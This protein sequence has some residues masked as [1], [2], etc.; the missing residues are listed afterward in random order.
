MAKYRQ[1][2]TEFWSDAFVL[3]LTPEEKYFYLYLISNSHTTQ[4]GIYELPKRIIETHTGYNRETVDK[5]LKRFEEYNKISY[6]DK[7]KEIMIINWAK[8][9]IPSNPNAIKCVNK[10]IKSVKNKEFIIIL[11]KQYSDLKLDMHKLFFGVED[12]NIG[13][14]KQDS[15]KEDIRDYEG[16]CKD[17]GSN[18]VISNKE[19]ITN[20]KEEVIE[21]RNDGADTNVGDVLL[22]FK[23]NVYNPT[24][25]EHKKILE[26]GEKINCD[27]IISA[28]EEAISYN[29]K[30]IKYIE[31]IINTWIDKKVDTP[32]KVQKYKMEWEKNK[33]KRSKKD[34]DAWDYE[35]QRE[36]N[37]EELERKLLGWD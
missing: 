34:S 5:L 13:T 12:L 9:N 33:N 1:I 18:K 25:F 8:Y 3:D 16:A 27:V 17:I 15:Y 10:E 23:N 36:Y 31:K 28:I 11:Y 24:E 7:T 32:E 35:G 20:N 37:F 29:A 26:W 6:C 2:H 22:F 30:S 19:E 14:L 4:C 21:I